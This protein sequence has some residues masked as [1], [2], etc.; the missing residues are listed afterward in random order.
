MPCSVHMIYGLTW[1]APGMT[2]SDVM[3]SAGDEGES[4]QP[5]KLCI[6]LYPFR[7]G[8]NILCTGITKHKPGI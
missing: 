8:Q 7:P 6:I 2:V 5:D 3:L 4:A 1:E